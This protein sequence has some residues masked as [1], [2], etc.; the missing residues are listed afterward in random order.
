MVGK[1]F[2]YV[3]FYGGGGMEGLVLVIVEYLV[4]GS[5]GEVLRFVIFVDFVDVDLCMLI[6]EK[7]RFM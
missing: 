1:L 4:I 3:V 6:E 5:F 2:V 7:V